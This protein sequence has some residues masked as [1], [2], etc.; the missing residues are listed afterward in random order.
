VRFEELWAHYVKMDVAGFSEMLV[1]LH[2]TS[3]R[4]ILLHS[5]LHSHRRGSPKSQSVCEQNGRQAFCFLFVNR[6]LPEF[7]EAACGEAR[8]RISTVCN[9][10][11]FSYSNPRSIGKQRSG[12]GEDLFMVDHYREHTGPETKSEIVLYPSFNPV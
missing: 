1:T 8:G 6:K 3:R 7:C 11:R 10:Y 5:N 9:L 12:F 2:Q 4:R